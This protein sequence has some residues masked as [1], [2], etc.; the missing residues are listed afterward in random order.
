LLYL[1][2]WRIEPLSLPED[3]NAAQVGWFET[4]LR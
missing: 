2:Q 4:S 1:K 3:K